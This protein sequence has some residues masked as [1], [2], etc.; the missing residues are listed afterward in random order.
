MTQNSELGQ[1]GGF[2]ALLRSPL[3]L[4]ACPVL[5]LFSGRA[6]HVRLP[7]A[8]AALGFLPDSR[9]QPLSRRSLDSKMLKMR[10][11]VQNLVEFPSAA[12]SPWWF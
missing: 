9:G 2:P 10:G 1:I 5:S 11:S 7:Y 3:M 4:L 12:E 8:L 6:R